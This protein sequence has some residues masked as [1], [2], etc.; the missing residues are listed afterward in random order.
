MRLNSAIQNV[1]KNPAKIK[2]CASRNTRFFG[3]KNDSL[4]MTELSA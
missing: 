3:Y 1:V 4:W 2:S